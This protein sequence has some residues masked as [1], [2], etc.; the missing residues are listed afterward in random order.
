MTILPWPIIPRRRPTPAALAPEPF[1][2]EV[3]DLFVAGI[4]GPPDETEEARTRRF[5]DQ[6]TAV[7]ALGPRDGAEAMLAIQCIMLSELTET[8]RRDS[9][10]EGAMGKAAASH[11]KAFEGLRAEFATLLRRFQTR[12]DH[13]PLSV[14]PHPPPG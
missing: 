2:N 9:G 13:P 10:A 8:A 11:A 12:R 1:T 14:P 4:P 5:Q 3:L 6:R 7:Q